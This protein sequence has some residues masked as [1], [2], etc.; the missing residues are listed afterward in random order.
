MS[1][2]NLEVNVVHVEATPVPSEDEAEAIKVDLVIGQVLPIDTGN[3]QP[4]VTPLGQISFILDRE[5]AD[6]IA[7]AASHLPEARKLPKDFTIASD[8]GQVEKAAQ[9]MRKVTGT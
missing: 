4:L 8:L 2:F 1:G 5:R 7:E 3:G 9:Q 6:K